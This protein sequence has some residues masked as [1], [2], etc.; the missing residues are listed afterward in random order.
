VLTSKASR[1][2][3]KSGQL[4]ILIVCAFLLNSPEAQA[5][6]ADPFIRKA[7]EIYRNVAPILF[8][9]GSFALFVSLGF[10]M[11]SERPNWKWPITI[12][13]ILVIL[14]V[15]DYVVRT[16]GIRVW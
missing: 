13:I 11:F 14:G 7:K 4:F 5:N 15:F 3:Y 9:L 2:F 6:F 1:R 16:I 10:N 12:A 8:F